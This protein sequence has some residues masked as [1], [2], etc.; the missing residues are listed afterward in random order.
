RLVVARD[1]RSAAEAEALRRPADMTA[2][3]MVFAIEQPQA[4]PPRDVLV[5]VSGLLWNTNPHVDAAAYRRTLQETIALLR[6]DGREVTLLAHVLDNPTPDNDV[7]AARELA[8]Q[9]GGRSE[10]RRVGKQ[11]RRV[12]EWPNLQRM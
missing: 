9:V 2:A 7:P 11:Q 4:G 12:R 8:G 3:D 5:N 1:P 6:A 10:E